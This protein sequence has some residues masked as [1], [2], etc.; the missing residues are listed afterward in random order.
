MNYRHLYHAGNFADVM[1]HTILLGLVNAFL[2]KDKP[3]CYLDTH[4]GIGCYDLTSS[5]SQKQAEYKAGAAK[6]FQLTD[7]P[8]LITPYIQAI[9]TLNIKNL[10]YYPGSP[11]FVKSL[12]RENDRML[13]CELHQ[14]DVQTLKQLFDANKQV[15]VHHLDGYQGLKAFLP[16]KEKRGLVLIDPPFEQPDEFQQIL[17]GLQ[18]ALARFS[19]GTYAIWYPLK[20]SYKLQHFKRSLQNLAVNNLLVAELAIDEIN[21]MLPLSGCGMVIIN[22]P[23]QVDK[24][25]QEMLAWLWPVLANERRGFYQVEWL[26]PPK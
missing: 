5:A 14:E 6:L 18:A 15:A 3:F 21:P 25:I 1:K 20:D 19:H 8:T 7:T 16:P 17:A 11:Y 22:T 26:I 4:A 10:R 9:K 24:S 12:L 23:W 13:L 2:G